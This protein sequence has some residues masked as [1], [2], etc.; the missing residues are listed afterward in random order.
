MY[1]PSETLHFSR[2]APQMS[3]YAQPEGFFF[4][5]SENIYYMI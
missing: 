2:S 4:F 1:T 3:L 5:V